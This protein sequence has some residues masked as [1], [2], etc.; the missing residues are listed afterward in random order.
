MIKY[1]VG[2]SGAE[3]RREMQRHSVAIRQ[4]L[5]YKGQPDPLK[6]DALNKAV[7]DTANEAVSAMF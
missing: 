4:L 5:H 2:K 7:R 3:F 1:A 6:G